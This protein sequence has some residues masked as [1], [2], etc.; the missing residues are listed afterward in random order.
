MRRRVFREGAYKCV[1]CGIQGEERR[2][3]RGGYGYYT[4]KP[5]VYLSIDHIKPKSKGGTNDRENLC[6]LCTTCNTEKGVKHA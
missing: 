6:V 5:G 3:P 4:E 2:F 1:S